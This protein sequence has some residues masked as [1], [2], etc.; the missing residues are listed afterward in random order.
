MSDIVSLGSFDKFI[1]VADSKDGFFAIESYE[2]DEFS[3]PRPIAIEIS[4][5]STE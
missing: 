5:D 3:E 2:K 1:Y 4:S